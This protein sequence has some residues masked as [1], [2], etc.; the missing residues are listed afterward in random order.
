M[1]KAII[2]DFDGLILDTETPQYEAWQQIYAQRGLGLS[3]RDW[4]SIVGG[5]TGTPFDPGVQLASQDPTLDADSLNQLADR[6]AMETI[7]SSPPLPGVASLIRQGREQGLK[8]AVASSSPHS[9]VDGHLQR[10]GL[11]DQFDT[12][13]CR[14][15]VAHP[16]PAPDLFVEALRRLDVL[17][18]QAL[19]L[20]DSPNGALAARRAGIACRVVRNPVTMLLAFEGDVVELDSLEQFVLSQFKAGG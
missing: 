4:G 10:L 3:L 16:K 15:D 11:F 17:P 13:V 5:Q 12:V 20:E 8:L 9:W 6:I 7:L 14:E 2:F 1:L 19:V 18:A